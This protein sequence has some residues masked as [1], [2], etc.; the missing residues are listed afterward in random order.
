MFTKS[1]IEEY[2]FGEKR[3]SL[4]FMAVGALAIVTALLSL[5]LSRQAY[6]RGAAIPMLALGLVLG[7]V[8]YTVFSRADRQRID[9]VYAYDMN[10]G[11][12]KQQELPRMQK[13]MRLFLL[14]RYMELVLLLIGISLFLYYRSNPAFA[15]WKGLGAALALMALIALAADFFAERRA[16][17]YTRGLIEL[18]GQMQ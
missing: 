2:F 17:A 5:L 6:Y 11:R 10:P 16:A 8:G 13:V 18:T 1:N 14:Y 12:L 4:I 7:I 3:E 9:N 15:F